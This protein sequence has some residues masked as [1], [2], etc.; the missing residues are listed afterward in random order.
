MSSLAAPPPHGEPSEAENA[1]PNKRSNSTAN[2]DADC[3]NINNNN[4]NNNNN[5]GSVVNHVT[6]GIHPAPNSEDG[7]L[8]LARLLQQQERAMLMMYANPEDESEDDEDVDPNDDVALAR[9]LQREE[10]REQRA[11]LLALAGVAPPRAQQQQEQQQEHLGGQE[12]AEGG[13]EEEEEEEEDAFQS[14]DDVNTDGMS[15]E[16]LLA[17]GEANGA[18]SKGAS[19]KSLVSVLTTCR[20]C[21]VPGARV[22]EQCSVC[23]DEFADMCCEVTVLPCKHYF[24]GECITPWLKVNRAC[25]L[26]FQDVVAASTATDNDR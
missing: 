15:Y 17:I 26:C 12:D 23:R 11:R 10:E 19:A 1:S 21:D 14:D 24:H 13:G 20:L 18:V 4:N 3:N 8:A 5:S 6:S 25:P 9:R 22:D 7:D 2:D 16:Q